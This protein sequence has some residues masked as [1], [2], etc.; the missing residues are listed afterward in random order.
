MVS[1][2]LVVLDTLRKDSFDAQFD[3]LPGRR[4]ERC[5]ATANWTAPAHGSLYTGRYPS[6]I[7]VSAKAPGLHVTDPVL[8]ER[9]RETGVTTRCWTAN[10]NLSREFAFDRGFDEFVDAHVVLNDDEDALNWAKFS[11]EHGDEGLLKYPRALLAAVG[12]EH[13]TIASLR[14]G[15]RSVTTDGQL[16]TVP[17]DGAASIRRRAERTAFTGEEFLV[18]NLMEAHS[19]YRPPDGYGDYDVDVSVAH[20]LG[21]EQPPPDGREAYEAAVEYLSD[22]YRDIHDV[23]STAFDY[24]ITMADHGEMLGEHG[25]W[26]HTYGLNP[27]IVHVPLVISGPEMDGTSDATVGH[28]DVHR[29]VLELFGLESDGRGENLLDT[30]DG[31]ERFAEYHGLVPTALDNLVER[32]VAAERIRAYDSSLVGLATPDEGYIFE[33]Q[34]GFGGVGRAAGLERLLAE[35]RRDVHQLHHDERGV[36]LSD[37]QRQRLEDLGYV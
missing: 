2:A 22:V 15:V 36:E 33:T 8:P 3:W 17:D 5:F 23:L 14:R 12:G 11:A 25:H 21:L 27:E 34:D 24:V 9:L 37:G 26:G 28:V 4:F 6:E 19:P 16:H 31:G 18:V 1:V 30:D 10:P 13:S 20:S 32:D 29:T 35:W 7:G